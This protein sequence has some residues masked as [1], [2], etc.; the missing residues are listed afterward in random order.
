MAE[1]SKGA[2]ECDWGCPIGQCTCDS[3][4]SVVQWL[5]RQP[6]LQR[7]LSFDG[8]YKVM[9][10]E[11]VQTSIDTTVDLLAEFLFVSKDEALSL[12]LFYQG[13][14][15]KLK[16]D[17][18]E[19]QTTIRAN[20]RITA[21]KGDVGK[22]N[23]SK[24][25]KC[26]IP[27]CD[28]ECDESNASRLPCG[29]WVCNEEFVS[30]LES[31]I[32]NDGKGALF[33]KCPSFGCDR[34]GCK[35][36]AQDNCACREAIP[37]SF[38]TKFVEDKVLLQKY[39]SWLY[40]AFVLGEEAFSFCPAPSCNYVC[41]YR[42]TVDSA[43][44]KDVQ[45]KCGHSYCFFC[46][47]VGHFPAPCDLS[48]KFLALLSAD[49]ESSTLIYAT[50]KMCPNKNCGVRIS[51]GADC[52]HV[53]C[54][55][56]THQFCW[57]CLGTWSSHGAGSGGFYVCK[58]YNEAVAVGNVSVEEKKRQELSNR[59]QKFLYF[60]VHFANHKKEREICMKKLTEMR[61]N[62][63]LSVKAQYAIDALTTCVASRTMLQWSVCLAYFLKQGIRKGL[64]EQQQETLVNITSGLQDSLMKTTADELVD[65]GRDGEIKKK[66][67]QGSELVKTL[68][69]GTT[70]AIFENG[71]WTFLLEEHDSD[72]KSWG[73][74][75]CTT[76]HGP[77]GGK[78]A[79]DMKTE[80]C[81][82]CFSCRMHS[83]Q[84]CK[85]CKPLDRDHW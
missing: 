71:L 44:D 7:C 27:F 51:K 72:D 12:L 39:H 66:I 28:V 16:N 85:A 30:Y 53:T 5:P 77:E 38:F 43:F 4:E 67:I 62:C 76:A 80:Y 46:H 58:K 49:D 32:V 45:C 57:L 6:S 83:T 24:T 42:M 74:M 84:R 21:R 8:S 79:A 23:G 65:G 81:K 64:F 52:N 3:S 10:L 68:M 17:W 41:E 54:S 2:V 63:D 36:Q 47:G 61:A 1:E 56:C 78:F 40:E 22:S 29:H 75:M 59:K 18:F 69:T 25:H 31:A 73:C 48:K 34:K 82:S 19:K 35:H 15:Q 14:E 70:K 11:E 37:S 13:K 33:L 50:T 20:A 9:P 55:Q 26:T 60:G